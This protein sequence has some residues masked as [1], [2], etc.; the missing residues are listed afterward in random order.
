MS[1][2]RQ[3]THTQTRDQVIRAHAADMLA[4]TNLAVED[5]AQA[6][7]QAC[8]SSFCRATL[9]EKKIPDIDGLFAAND[10]DGL[11]KAASRWH[12]RVE[13]WL[14]EDGVEVP[15]WLEEPWITAL[16]PEWRER[17]L[18]ELASRYGL[19]AVRPVG[20]EGMGPMK[21]FS[22]LMGRMGEVAGLG[23]KVFDDLVINEQDAE[24]LPGL[25]GGLRALSAKAE[26][27]AAAAEKVMGVSEKQGA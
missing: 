2:P 27:L 6:L 22:G 17:C 11:T 16:L 10:V 9:A 5:F 23:A 21:V 15:V 20:V 18:I 4:R 12:K 7:Y 26:T 25:I 1:N 14:D 13:R 24:H 3:A 19:L 8:A